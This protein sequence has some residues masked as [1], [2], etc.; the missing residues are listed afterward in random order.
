MDTVG[1]LMH[2]FTPPTGWQPSPPSYLPPAHNELTPPTSWQPSVP[3]YSP[4]VHHFPTGNVFPRLSTQSPDVSSLLGPDTRCQ[5]ESNVPPRLPK[6]GEMRSMHESDMLERRLLDGLRQQQEA[7][8][9]MREVIQSQ[10]AEVVTCGHRAVQV[11]ECQVSEMLGELQTQVSQN[12]SDTKNQHVNTQSEL[13]NK[14]VV[15]EMRE[16][17]E[18][19]GS[20][21]R[22]ANARTELVVRRQVEEAL[23]IVSARQAA[24]EEVEEST[25]G[26]AAEFE[27]QVREALYAQTREV[28]AANESMAANLQSQVTA[29]L[30]PVTL[31]V[32]QVERQI[33]ADLARAQAGE[34]EACHQLA[35]DVH[36]I[37]EAEVTAF[38]SQKVMEQAMQSQVAEA[39]ELLKTQAREAEQARAAEAKKAHETDAAHQRRL[40]EERE[41]QKFEE[42][43]ARLRLE[44]AEERQKR[45]LVENERLEEE[46]RRQRQEEV[47]RREEAVRKQLEWRIEKREL[48]WR[49]EQRELEWKSRLR[50]LEWQADW[51]AARQLEESDLLQPPDSNV[52]RRTRSRSQARVRE[53]L[54]G[55]I[56]A[57]HDSDCQTILSPR[58]RGR[59]GLAP[60]VEADDNMVTQRIN[61]SPSKPD[62]Q[63]ETCNEHHQAA[64]PAG[65]VPPPPA[66]LPSGKSTLDRGIH[67]TGHPP[68]PSTGLRPSTAGAKARSSRSARAPGLPVSR[69]SSVLTQDQSRTQS[70]SPHPARCL[71]RQSSLQHL[72][73][74]HGL[75]E[76]VAADLVAI[77]SGDPKNSAV[78]KASRSAASC[79]TIHPRGCRQPR[80]K[81]KASNCMSYKE[82]AEHS[83]KWFDLQCAKKRD[84]VLSRSGSAKPRALSA[85]VGEVCRAYPEVSHLLS[86]GTH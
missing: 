23:A 8:E 18:V 3:S 66:Q 30:T 63:P 7:A 9:T 46:L 44:I 64:P 31:H 73:R 49:S 37:R 19:Q 48:H 1:R 33:A 53:A 14:H 43:T 26:N 6:S 17:L 74:R 77:P 25:G 67:T 57:S 47:K 36:R 55:A 41:K 2:E 52:E 82:I 11:A 29:T 86:L 54:M 40:D 42:S 75:A 60:A 16:A 59:C 70:H 51:K 13:L 72:S 4:P 28:R 24:A 58:Q 15:E 65:P 79:N 62:L 32:E 81:P 80:A 35:A 85:S 22:E 10:L 38:A 83:M 12:H 39:M 84:D 69:S 34:E 78:E 27:M 68:K 20:A 61:I 21:I 5:I 76:A 50:Q 56:A 45:S 71:R